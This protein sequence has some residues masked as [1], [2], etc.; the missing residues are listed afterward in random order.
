MMNRARR[1]VGQVREK[2]IEQHDQAVAEPDQI[3][4]VHGEPR[5]PRDDPA[6]AHAATLRFRARSTDRRHRALVHMAE[7]DARLPEHG[8]RD[9]PCASCLCPQNS[10]PVRMTSRWLLSQHHLGKARDPRGGTDDGAEER[11][12]D[13]FQSRPARFL[14]ALVQGRLDSRFRSVGVSSPASSL[15]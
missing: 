11:P 1:A 13:R 15:G 9:V 4:H 6:A 8:P 14:G 5:H 2:P 10:I 7:Q 3:Q 12:G